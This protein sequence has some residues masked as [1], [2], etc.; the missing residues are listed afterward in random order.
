MRPFRLLAPALLVLAPLSMCVL[1]AVPAAAG[2]PEDSSQAFRARYE[3]SGAPRVMVF[4]NVSFSDQ[5]RSASQQV[6]ITRDI[7]P[8]EMQEGGGAS[9]PGQM[10]TTTTRTIDP[11]KRHTGLSERDA[12]RLESAFREGL[13]GAG[14]KLIDRAKSVRF[15]A[16]DRDRNGVDPKLIETDA[17]RA[18]TELLLEVLLVPDFMSPLGRGFI[19]RATDVK[20]GAE[21]AHV[22]TMAMP[23]LPAPT[24]HYE[25]TDDGFRWQNAP[26]QIPTPEQI[27]TTLADEVL[28]ALEPAL[29]QMQARPRSRN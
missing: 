11:E 20:D 10:H 7:V 16:A 18:N 1:S 19:V 3:A 27:G 8:G 26:P 5:T 2:A 28:T 15:M 23:A 25:L 17:V 14:V 12:A 6:E 22:Y 21:V 9:G 24:G 4:W 29:S 13:R